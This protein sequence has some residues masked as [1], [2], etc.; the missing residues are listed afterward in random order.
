MPIPYQL[1]PSKTADIPQLAQFA[2][3]T[4]SIGRQHL[5]LSQLADALKQ[6]GAD[7]V[8]GSQCLG[9]DGM[10]AACLATRI[11][12]DAA[13]LVGCSQ[14]EDVAGSE[15]LE[16]TLAHLLEQ[17]S[18]IG[19]R[20]V[21]ACWDDSPDAPPFEKNGFQFIANLDYLAGTIENLQ[22]SSND[23]PERV[24]VGTKDS[25]TAPNS[26]EP[27][28]ATETFDPDNAQ[29]RL[30]IYKVV[31]DTFEKTLD[32]PRL[33]HFRPPQT[34]VDAYLDSPAF[35]PAGWR[36]FRQGGKPIACLI[37][38]P[39]ASANTLELT[40]MGAIPEVR[41][42]GWGGK[43]IDEAIVI[44]KQFKLTELIL[45][46]DTKNQPAIDIYHRTGL[47]SIAKEAVW[48]CRLP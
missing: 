15:L 14:T 43:I 22:A 44:A 3:R 33:N 19:I 41:G 28:S 18:A 46:V 26:P 5:A 29:D 31:A 39:Y 48:G 25:S 38:T 8:F 6:R 47:T 45:A 2:T 16:Q 20:F 7:A 21:Q 27:T 36:I 42:Q 30:D 13:M 10:L 37:T 4:L 12:P 11:S 17:L 1:T 23:Q 35:E 9:T 24:K 40:Y 32:C 34:I